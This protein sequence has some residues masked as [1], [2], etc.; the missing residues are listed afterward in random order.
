MDKLSISEK[1]PD[2]VI[3]SSATVPVTINLMQV[4]SSKGIYFK[5]AFP[6]IVEL[7]Q[8]NDDNNANIEAIID[9]LSKNK[10]G[11][12][13]NVVR[14]PPRIAVD[15]NKTKLF[16]SFSLRIILAKEIANSGCNFWINTT[17]DKSI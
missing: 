15:A 7:P 10:N 6:S 11:L 5:V 17:T 4:I 3:I 16:D 12:L 2:D 1:F 8:Q 13:P 9:L 14:Y